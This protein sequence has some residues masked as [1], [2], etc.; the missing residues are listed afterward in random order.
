[1]PVKYV[2][3][4]CGYV[5]DGGKEAPFDSL[6]ESWKCPLCGAPKGEFRPTEAAPAADAAAPAPLEGELGPF[7]AG[8]MAA[9]CSS[10][11][12]GCEKQYKAEEA[13]LFRELA[14]WFA[15]AEPPSEGASV[16]ALADALR[17]DVADYPSLRAAADTAG[18]RGAARICV[19]G[20]KVTRML[21]SLLD[22]YGR[23][24]EAMLAGQEIWVCTTCGFVWI[25]EA[26]PELCPVCKVPAW[27]FE[28]AE[29]GVRA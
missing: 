28:K 2:C 21:S 5:Y 23:E 24:G 13:A 29:G 17:A 22:R 14:A 16:E 1:M 18:D 15:A 7:T 11:G 10:L 26:P 20:E 6:P 3:Q 19:W 4:V 12:R 27:K 8:Q 9:L 25:G